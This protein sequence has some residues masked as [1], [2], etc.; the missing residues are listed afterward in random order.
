MVFW[1]GPEVGAEFTVT[2][3]YTPVASAPVF[4]A[5]ELLG[6]GKVQLTLTG[7]PQGVYELLSS[8]NLKVWSPLAVVTNVQGQATYTA[9][10][11]PD[12]PILFFNAREVRC[13]G[14]LMAQAL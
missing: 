13:R 7:E 3:S 2:Y 9:P 12:R 4:S 6:S 1:I 5:I 14:A 10:V 11:M 8:T